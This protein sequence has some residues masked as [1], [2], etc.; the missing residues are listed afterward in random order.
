VAEQR[1]AQNQQALGQHQIGQ[2]LQQQ[3]GQQRMAMDQAR[4]QNELNQPD[5]A[6]EAQLKAVQAYLANEMMVERQKEIESTRLQ[7][8][9]DLAAYKNELPLT[10]E[11]QED[12]RIRNAYTQALT[13]NVGAGGAGGAGGEVFNSIYE[14]NGA[15]WLTPQQKQQIAMEKGWITDTGAPLS[16]LVDAMAQGELSRLQLGAEAAKSKSAIAKAQG[17]KQMSEATA[18]WILSPNNWNATEEQKAAAEV[19][20]GL[21]DAVTQNSLPKD[22]VIEWEDYIKPKAK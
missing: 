6:E 4:L 19:V 14:L 1:L 21:A 10:P 16:G 15:S 20:L 2:A 12:R 9:K 5:A 8:D 17:G 7:H 18:R 13:G 3:Q 22:A 11:E